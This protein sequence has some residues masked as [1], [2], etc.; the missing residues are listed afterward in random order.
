MAV[1]YNWPVAIPLS[2][3]FPPMRFC[4]LLATI[5]LA[6]SGCRSEDAEPG[7]TAEANPPAPSGVHMTAETQ[8]ANGLATQTIARRTVRKY[9]EAAAWLRVEPGRQAVLRAPAAGWVTPP[10]QKEL[11]GPGKNVAA[12]EPL[13]AFEILL[14][15]QDR[16]QWISAAP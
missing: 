12:G 16:M 11:P 10:E 4:P 7:R 13:A 9:L 2:P 3:H 6:F 8:R 14:S 15:P 1:M 5:L